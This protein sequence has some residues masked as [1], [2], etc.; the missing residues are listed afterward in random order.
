[1]KTKMFNIFILYMKIYMI[2]GITLTIISFDR[3]DSELFEFSFLDFFCDSIDN[4]VLKYLH[5]SYV[6]Y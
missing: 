2:K 6:I 4:I 3:M 1:M 5:L